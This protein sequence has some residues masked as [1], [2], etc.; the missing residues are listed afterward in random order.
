MNDTPVNGT[1]APG[2]QSSNY[3]NSWRT[4]A[5]VFGWSW[6]LF[7]G[8]LAFG[9]L[10]SAFSDKS[11]V[12]ASVASF[13]LAV[14]AVILSFVALTNHSWWLPYIAVGLAVISVILDAY[15]LLQPAGREPG[16]LALNLYSLIGDSAA[17]SITAV[18]YWGES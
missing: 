18:E 13:V 6:S 5:D 14:V 9:M 7:S 1:P 4:W 17:A 11:D 15:S 10:G 3:A 16:W 2:T 12:V 8:T